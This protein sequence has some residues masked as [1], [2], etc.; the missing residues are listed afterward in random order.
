MSS[1]G[2]GGLL[3]LGSAEPCGT[4]GSPAQPPQLRY[5]SPWL[6]HPFPYGKDQVSHGYRVQLA[7]EIFN[8]LAQFFFPSSNK[9]KE[10]FCAHYLV[11]TWRKKATGSRLQVGR[12]TSCGLRELAGWWGHLLDPGR[13]PSCR[14]GPGGMR[15]PG[16]LSW[17]TLL[18]QRVLPRWGIRSSIP[19]SMGLFWANVLNLLDFLGGSE[20]R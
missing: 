1:R 12:L 18:G 11:R 19:G 20:D 3:S 5:S 14:E 9:A 15:S 2:L 8:P 16:Q 7:V 6:P 13:A 4:P 17:V 10:V